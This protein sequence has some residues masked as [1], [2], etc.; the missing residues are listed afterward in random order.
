MDSPAQTESIG[1][2][3][4]R[5]SHLARFRK[6]RY[7]HRLHRSH[8]VSQNALLNIEWEGKRTRY[9]PGKRATTTRPLTAKSKWR[10]VRRRLCKARALDRTVQSDLSAATKNPFHRTMENCHR[11]PARIATQNTRGKSSIFSTK[12]IGMKKSRLSGTLEHG[13]Y[14]QN[15]FRDGPHFPYWLWTSRKVSGGPTDLSWNVCPSCPLVLP[16]FPI[17][18]RHVDSAAGKFA[19]RHLSIYRFK[20]MPAKR[21]HSHPPLWF[22]D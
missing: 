5:L 2:R 11:V 7:Q 18:F 16:L 20:T 17:V 9:S 21:G 15:Q 6:Y 1:K 19:Y 10:L 14:P 4:V 8:K 12:Q 13:A 3:K 22:A